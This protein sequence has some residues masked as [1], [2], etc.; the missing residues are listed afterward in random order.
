MRERK[1]CYSM[2]Q[3]PF[4]KQSLI[5]SIFI[6]NLLCSM[7]CFVVGNTAVNKNCKSLISGLHILNSLKTRIT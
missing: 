6:E 3:V 7:F 1:T 2:Q 4:T 5:L